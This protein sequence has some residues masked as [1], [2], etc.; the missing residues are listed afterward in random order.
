MNHRIQK[1]DNQ[2]HFVA[3]FGSYGTALGNFAFPTG[4]AVD[5]NGNIFVSDTG[6]NR[7]QK[8]SA[9][10]FFLAG[11][12]GYGWGDGQF[13]QPMGIAVDSNG[14]VFV[15]DRFNN[16][17]QKFTNNGRFVAKWGTNGGA[18]GPDYIISSGSGAG[19][20]F[21]PIGVTVDPA[22][23]VY[24]TDSSNNRV[25]KFSNN[26][27]FIAKFGRFS[28]TD[29]NFFPPRVSPSTPGERFT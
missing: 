20:F 16:R 28:G 27:A 14:N 3:S 7:I 15:V 10:F 11:W 1:F 4:V 17:V 24:V 26:G 23:N 8:F 21:L 2:G 19:D 12:G 6:N 29:G 13:N 18:G 25:Q 5:G 9:N 22:G